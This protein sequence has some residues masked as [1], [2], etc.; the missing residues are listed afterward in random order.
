MLRAMTNW[1]LKLRFIISYIYIYGCIWKYLDLYGFIYIYMIYWVY[2]KMACHPIFWG[3]PHYIHSLSSSSE[4][5]QG[6]AQK[7]Q[8]S[9]CLKLFTE[10]Y[11][12]TVYNASYS[13]NDINLI[14]ELLN[15]VNFLYSI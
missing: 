9:S 12:V 1:V 5:F 4:I 6:E 8:N 15:V 11:I 14:N 13:I 2:E 10:D 3:L 7:K